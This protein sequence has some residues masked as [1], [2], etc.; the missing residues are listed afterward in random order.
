MQLQVEGLACRVGGLVLFDGWSCQVGPGVTLVQGGEGRGKSTLLRLLA[1]S[2][3]ADAGWLQIGSRRL[4]A[5]PPA[6]RSQV[7][8]ADLRTDAFDQIT[9]LAYLAT[10]QARYRGFDASQ[11]AALV[12]G[13]SLTEHQH[14]PMYMLST[15]SRRKVWFAAAA[16]CGAPLTLVDEPFAALDKRSMVFVCEVLRAATRRSDRI[17]ILADYEPPPDVPLAGTIDL[18]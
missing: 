10:V 2:Q 12:E 3:Q 13:L 16:A 1:G 18:G 15:G 8:Q 5:D 9:P 14:K 4:D 7:F 6:Y 17:W 11:V